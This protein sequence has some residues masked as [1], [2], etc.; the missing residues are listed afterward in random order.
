M[1]LVVDL[2]D[3]PDLTALVLQLLLHTVEHFFGVEVQHLVLTA[4]ADI[5]VGPVEAETC[6]VGAVDLNFEVRV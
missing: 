3:P 6:V 1:S 4:D 5:N 2:R